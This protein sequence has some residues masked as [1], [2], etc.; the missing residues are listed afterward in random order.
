MSS[1]QRKNPAKVQKVWIGNGYLRWVAGEEGFEPSNAGIR[2]R[3]LNQLGDSPAVRMR[4]YT[5]KSEKSQRLKK[6]PFILG[7]S[8][9]SWVLNAWCGFYGIGWDFFDWRKTSEIF[10]RTRPL[11]MTDTKSE[12]G[13]NEAGWEG[14][15]LWTIKLKGAAY[16]DVDLRCRQTKRPE[17]NGPFSAGE[18]TSIGAIG[19]G[20]SAPIPISNKVRSYLSQNKSGKRQRH[21]EYAAFTHLFFL[22]SS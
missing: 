7:L 12:G 15:A 9:D 21:A 8:R 14:L 19:L 16:I 18:S 10:L 20:C 11:E 22:F 3:C 2:I 13:I 17:L 1:A 5:Q 6:V 4:N